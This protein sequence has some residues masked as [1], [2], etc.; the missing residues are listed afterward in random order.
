MDEEVPSY[1]VFLCYSWADG[2]AAD[3]MYGAM[4]A[5][6]LSVFQDK[7]EGELY[8]PLGDS[9]TSALRRSRT[10]VALM[11][12]RLQD[13]PHCREELHLA[14]SAAARLGDTS[15]V[16]AVVL[17]MSP[18]EVRPRELTRFR[19]P[20]TATP[21]AN[22]AAEITAVVKR[23]TGVF[24]DAPLRPNPPWYPREHVGNTRFQGRWDELWEIRHG[25]R[26]RSRNADRG[27]PVVVVTGPGGLGKTALTVQY[28]RWFAQEHPGGV[29]LFELGGSGANSN[30]DAAIRMAFRRQLADV[31]ECMGV[32]GPEAV[33][34]TLV[35]SGLPYLWLLDDLPATVCPELVDELCA[36]TAFGYTLITTRGRIDRPASATI[37]L[38]RLSP[39]MGRRVLISR[40]RV[41]PG[42][43]Q[44]VRDI[45]NLLG[46]HPLGLTLAS[47]LSTLPDF[48][49]Y[50]A[51]FAE[52]ASAEPDRLES[53]AGGLV[54]ELPV[55]C[56]RPFAVA[57]LRSFAA[58]PGA[59]R[60]AL[61]ALSVLSPTFVSDDLLAAMAGESAPAALDVATDRGLVVRSVGGCTMHALTARA[62][63][64]QTFPA[65]VRAR[66]RESALRAL[67][68]AVE[69]TRT[70]YRHAK[71]AHHLPHVRAVTGLLRGGDAWAIGP[72]ERYLLHE[73]GRTEIEAG[74]SGDALGLLQTLYDACRTAPG[75]DAETVYAVA[76]A[77][78]AAHQ[79]Q[80][81]WSVALGLLEKA[82]AALTREIGADHPDAVTVRHNLGLAHLAAGRPNRAYGF[83]R[84]AYE[85]RRDHPDL[86][87]L[88]RETLLALNS[89][90]LVRG[91]LGSTAAERRRSQQ[92]AHRLWL[93][94]RARWRRVAGPDDQYALDVLNGLA[95]SCR[96]IGCL[97]EA[98]AILDDLRERR[99]HL[100]GSEHPDTLSTAEN[101]LIVRSELGEETADGLWKVLLGRL[102]GQGP[103]H[104][105]TGVT[106]ANLIRAEYGSAGHRATLGNRAV[107]G[108]RPE[109]VAE[110]PGVVRLDGD[111]TDTEIDLQQLA[112]YWQQDCT[113][114]FGSDDPRSL[115]ATCLLAYSLAGANHV[116]GQVGLAL[117]ELE[118][119]W[120]AIADAAET[121]ELSSDD[122]EIATILRDWVRQSAGD[123]E[124]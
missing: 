92:A 63:R 104:P 69:A 48:A 17:D 73:T 103:G 123:Q 120:P 94:A 49:G 72:D 124:A 54:G 20:R 39:L 10:L 19:L 5:A 82:V 27:K 24:G 15:R 107:L 89:L 77:L 95:L 119:S 112:I 106:M 66:Y 115:M 113:D 36:P 45:V 74:H 9:I 111:H 101:A 1:E 78:A 14:L 75:A 109:P 71:I 44:A 59:T 52:L 105:R 60:A 47:G 116:D 118:E 33:A 122:L 98:V 6:G 8:A 83:V 53:V 29:F 117:E 100:L 85:A 70:S 65:G 87:P 31:A 40:R 86:G 57:L 97:D 80:G 25:M 102:R 2:D 42:E 38:E 46:G 30:S 76:T 68:S 18:E 12:P 84:E 28:A 3:A 13:S 91:H 21:D 43:Q 50:P 26:A 35:A 34:P 88:H 11:S 64:V 56:V 16:M 79:E 93:G 81:N 108:S 32:S 61:T 99:A 55:G 23:H 4:T 90:A 121:G 114:R 51:L 37:S 67:T 110:A 22:L 62:I 7:V 96:A 41:S 58:L